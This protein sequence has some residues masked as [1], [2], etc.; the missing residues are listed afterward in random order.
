MSITND[1]LALVERIADAP[2]VAPVREVFV[3]PLRDRPDPS[4]EF[5][6]VVLEDGS[7]G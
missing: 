4:A 2:L 1:Y 7:V 5:G 3:P 6:A